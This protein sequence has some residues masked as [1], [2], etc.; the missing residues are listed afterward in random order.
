VARLE[1]DCGGF[2]DDGV[3]CDAGQVGEPRVDIG[4]TTSSTPRKLRFASIRSS[5]TGSSFRPP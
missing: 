3:L 1:T 2:E 5:R 4:V